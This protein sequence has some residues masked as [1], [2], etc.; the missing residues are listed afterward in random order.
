MVRFSLGLLSS[1][2]TEKIVEYS[3]AAEDF[4]YDFVWLKEE[5]P[6][7]LTKDP[8]TIMKAIASNTETI[9]IGP[10]GLNPMVIEPGLIASYT[11]SLS[12]FSKGRA[13]TSIEAEPERASK[14]GLE[15]IK[16]LLAGETVDFSGEIFKVKS[17]KLPTKPVLTSCHG[18][19]DIPLYVACN[20]V[21][22]LRWAGKNADGV[23]VSSPLKYFP[24]VMTEIKAG[25]DE[26]GRSL[27]GFD[28]ANWLPWS[29]SMDMKEAREFVKPQVA[30]VIA[31]TPLEITQSVGLK[32]EEVQRIRQ[33]LGAE[34]DKIATLVT[35]EMVNHFSIC[36]PYWECNKKAKE[37]IKLGGWP[38]VRGRV[39]I[40][41]GYPYG[42]S[43]VEAI[44]TIGDETVKIFRLPYDC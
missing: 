21:E 43:E 18:P 40:V 44:K 10:W 34:P 36:G 41:V 19:R 11:A 13:V 30:K 25:A 5:L 6:P 3:K 15:I 26:V 9:C 42:P 22:S 8:Y 38:D 2:Q 31:Q 28:V 4:Y 12:E 16:S 29:I 39:Q 32:D 35:E 37:L 1:I 23:L 27:D 20:S 33:T 7:T 24:T 17:L 14:E